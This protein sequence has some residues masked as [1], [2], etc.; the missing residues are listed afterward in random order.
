MLVYNTNTA[1]NTGLVGDGYYFWNG[2]Q[3]EKY[4]VDTDLA[5]IDRDR[6]TQ[7]VEESPDDD[8][9]RLDAAGVE[10]ATFT[11]TQ[12]HLNTAITASSTLAVSGNATV[13][14]DFT[15]VGSSTLAA[16]TLEAA[17]HDADGDAG[18][19]GQILSSTGISTNWVNALQEVPSLKGVGQLT[20]TASLAMGGARSVFVQGKYAYVASAA[21]DS[22]QVIDIS[23]PIL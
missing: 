4:I 13:S 16:T 14:G 7:Q 17:L 3:W 20:D 15:V 2:T 23:R 12:T 10:V 21:E 1:T 9:I 6:D 5:L 8:T 18:I 22:F 19:K 11:A